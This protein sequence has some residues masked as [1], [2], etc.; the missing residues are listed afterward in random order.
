MKSINQGRKIIA[1]LLVLLILCT[2]LLSCSSQSKVVM[3]IGKQTLSLNMYE[4]MLSRVKGNLAYNGYPT[5]DAAFWAEMI[6]I[7]GNTYSDYFCSATQEQAKMLLVQLYL[8]EEVYGLTLPTQAYTDID[9][10][11][12]EIVDL[13]HNGSKT[14]FNR[15]LASYGVNMDMLRENYIL[16]E[17]IDSLKQYLLQQTGDAARAEYYEEHYVRFR[18]I[19]LPLYRYSYETDENEDIIYYRE[20][21]DRI[22]Y[23]INGSFQTD[24]NGKVVTDE[25]GDVIYYTEDGRIAYNT[26]KGVKRGIDNDNDGNV[27]YVMMDSEDA[28]IVA[29]QAELLRA[30]IEKGDVTT[31]ESYGKQLSEAALWETYPGGNY[32]NLDKQYSVAYLDDFQN[33]LT[34]MQVGD[35]ALIQSD[36]AYHIIMKY[37][38]DAEG[39]KDDANSDWFEEFDDEVVTE[40][41]NNLCR[42]YLEQVMV[43]QG[44]LS[45]AADMTTIGTNTDY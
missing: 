37:E 32:I 2:T 1:L 4:L 17:K 42:P 39:Y 33:Q 23:D 11:L 36:T 38:L 9:A 8:F 10:E 3:S 44:V 29:D 13:V 27:D 34:S 14:A 19:L 24:A 15:E 45:S 12:A 28:Q 21:S 18:Q 20:G 22:Y 43:D 30:T 6:N 25:N 31:F 5:D 41:L 7:A 16:E 26:E 40:I 35:I